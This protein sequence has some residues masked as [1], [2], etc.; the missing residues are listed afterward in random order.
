MIDNGWLMVADWDADGYDD[1]GFYRPTDT[2]F[3]MDANE[4]GSYDCSSAFGLKSFSLNSFKYSPFH[5][6]KHPFWD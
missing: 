6:F 5:L 3:F 4:D 1:L 2:T